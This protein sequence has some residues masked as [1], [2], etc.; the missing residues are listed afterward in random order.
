MSILHR[1]LFV[2]VMTFGWTGAHALESA[3][4]DQPVPETITPGSIKHQLLDA[5]Q[6]NGTITPA[7]RKAATDKYITAADDT[8]FDRYVENTSWTRH[9]TWSLS[10]KL[11]GLLLLFVAMW[12]WLKAFARYF[13]GWLRKIPM[14]VYQGVLFSTSLA[15][16]LFPQYIYASHAFD[17]ALF[18]AFTTPLLLVWIFGTNP[19]LEKFIAIM[20]QNSIVG[21][22]LLPSLGA[23]YFL[24]VAMAYHSQILGV[25]AMWFLISIPYLLFSDAIKKFSDSWQQYYMNAIAAHLCITGMWLW[26]APGS[27]NPAVEVLTVA[28]TYYIPVAMCVLLTYAMSPWFS[29]RF[30]LHNVGHFG[31]FI[32]LAAAS[33]SD[34]FAPMPAMNSMLMVTGVLTAL[35]WIVDR[36]FSVGYLCGTFVTGT[37]LYVLS[38]NIDTLRSWLSTVH[39][40]A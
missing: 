33:F 36:S 29:R 12:G 8:R 34:V 1:M 32:M 35:F 4:S 16:L 17:V 23:S 13:N 3:T 22:Y 9:V 20:F 14:P 5:L 11:L 28:A 40:Q 30:T 21:R 15:G 37:A 2:L 7:Q 25:A 24:N 6:K 26:L 27:T 39:F 10:L 31:L 38:L 18:C 19:V